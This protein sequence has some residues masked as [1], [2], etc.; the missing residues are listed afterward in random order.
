MNKN[1]RNE[2][3]KIMNIIVSKPNKQRY[4]S[5]DVMIVNINEIRMNGLSIVPISVVVGRYAKVPSNIERLSPFLLKNKE[6]QS[7][8]R[9]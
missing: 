3:F 4:S 9:R 1:L 8:E 7:I 6:D 5:P 2:K